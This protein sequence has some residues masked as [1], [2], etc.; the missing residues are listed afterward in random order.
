MFIKLADIGRAVADQDAAPV[1]FF[2]EKIK[3]T[4]NKGIRIE[5]NADGTQFLGCRIEK[6]NEEKLAEIPYKRGTSGGYNP[7]PVAMDSGQGDKSASNAY[8]RKLGGY[9]DF[10]AGFSQDPRVHNLQKTWQTE[11]E[12]IL[13]AMKLYLEQ[14]KSSRQDN[15]FFFLS[16]A[17]QALWEINEIRQDIDT[18]I[19]KFVTDNFG[20][21]DKHNT[22]A[23]DQMCALCGE[24]RAE[25][26]GN[27]TLVQS[28]NLD[29]PGFIAGGARPEVGVKNLPICLDCAGYLSKGFDY[30][31]N[32]L[33]FSMAGMS[34]L[35]LP[36]MEGGKPDY[37]FLKKVIR[38]MESEKQRQPLA[39]EKLKQLTGKEDRILDKLGRDYGD[40]DQLVL[41]WVFYRQQAAQWRILGEFP[42]VL[43]S[44]LRRVYRAK[45]E[46]ESLPFLRKDKKPDHVSINFIK[47]VSKAYSKGE[48]KSNQVMSYVEAI[49]AGGRL[50]Y[51]KVLKDVVRLVVREYKAQ[52]TGLADYY[53]RNG[54][55]FL[56]FLDRLGVI[57]LLPKGV[58]MDVKTLP[59]ERVGA[60]MDEYRE[61]FDS[62]GKRVAF[63]T[64]ILVS[65]I[66]QF[67]GGTNAF[68]K[69]LG[70]YR[71]DARK[72]KHLRPRIE[73]KIAAYDREKHALAI[74]RDLRSTLDLLW[75]EWENTE[76]TESDDDLTLAVLMGMNLDY[77]VNQ[78]YKKEENNE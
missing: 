24:K 52:N 40:T 49:F 16:L 58:N 9:L 70:D 5:F 71:F 59:A 74:T 62:R 56:Y 57:N 73:A 27:V 6:F 66:L 43:P 60:F 3:K 47:E 75:A 13:D 50:S 17:G 53:V 64:G 61:F 32:H 78:E 44:R 23:L 41:T 4:Y 21:K 69:E 45:Q 28:Y 25:V 38:E 11:K 63:V 77:Y 37:P 29:Q 14:A 65:K 10:L 8:K 76:K 7:V 34:Y 54:V 30:A 55:L 31:S 19:K 33:R 1:E 46:A 22:L 2:Y 26:F 42:R 72:L 15:V 48:S 35:M 20:K 67:Q 12:A 68:R 18:G 39:G 36:G 51:K